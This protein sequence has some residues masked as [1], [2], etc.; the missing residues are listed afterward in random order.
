MSENS[1]AWDDPYGCRDVSLAED[2][3]DELR[4]QYAELEQAYRLQS[5]NRQRRIA[6]LKQD[7]QDM[8]DENDRLSARTDKL[9]VALR[10]IMN[11][12]DD[13]W[14]TPMTDIA[15]DIARKALGEEA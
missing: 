6:E 3:V 7:L 11:E 13:N 14:F 5:E 4:R 2:Y 9:E 15:I 8:D 1:E 12:G 10:Y